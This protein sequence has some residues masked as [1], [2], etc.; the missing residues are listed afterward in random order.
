VSAQ[1][2]DTILKHRLAEGGAGGNFT[3]FLDQ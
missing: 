1:K 3:S 2:F